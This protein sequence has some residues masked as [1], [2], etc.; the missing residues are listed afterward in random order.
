MA[1]E[2][3]A[4]EVEISSLIAQETKAKTD[5]AI[6]RAKNEQHKEATLKLDLEA[7]K[8]NLIAIGDVN[9]AI[10]AVMN[11]L[12]GRLLSM[13]RKLSA[14]LSKMNDQV[15]CHRLLTDTINDMLNDM[16]DFDIEELASREGEAAKEKSIKQIGKTSQKGRQYKLL[17][18]E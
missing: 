11:E 1:D 10:G 2:L 4:Q 13:P 16:K 12:S 17:M 8:G 3:T 18:I 5:Y 14:R 7:R 15:D 9:L 6:F